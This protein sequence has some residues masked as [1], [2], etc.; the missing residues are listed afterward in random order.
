MYIDF[1]RWQILSGNTSNWFPYNEDYIDTL[2]LDGLFF[3]ASDPVDYEAAMNNWNRILEQS[4]VSY[5][6][7]TQEYRY[8]ESQKITTWRCFD[9]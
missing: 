3:L 5:D 8:L 4:E 2:A 9:F 1:T 7:E 6:E